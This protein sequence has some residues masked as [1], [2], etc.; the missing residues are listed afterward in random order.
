MNVSPPKS[1]GVCIW[2]PT[3][4]E[5]VDA[6]Q[7]TYKDIWLIGGE[8]IYTEGLQYADEIYTTLIPERVDIAGKTCARFPYVHPLEFDC[9]K[10]MMSELVP[11]ADKQKLVVAIY[12]PSKT[13]WH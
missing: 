7:G 12:R 8:G 9:E 2:H 11:A 5:A 1:D 4:K 13:V 3:L 6:P 10:R